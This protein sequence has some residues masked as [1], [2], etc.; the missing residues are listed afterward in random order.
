[1]RNYN[2][3]KSNLSREI[4][5]KIFKE[6]AF[7]RGEIQKFEVSPWAKKHKGKKQLTVLDSSA[8]ALQLYHFS[9]GKSSS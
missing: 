9:S 1:M 2:E 8:S 6:K 7:S 5:K 4:Q 3:K